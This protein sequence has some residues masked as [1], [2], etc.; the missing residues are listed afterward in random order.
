LQD[1][2]GSVYLPYALGRKYPKADKEFRWQ[3]LFPAT[4]ISVDPRSGIRRRHHLYQGVVQRYIKRTADMIGITKRVTCHTF[5]HSFAT[6]LLQSGADIR[7]VQQLLGHNDLKTT[8]IYT[9]VALSGPTGTRSPL[10]NAP[11]MSM[12]EPGFMP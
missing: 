4:Q 11:I 7:T 9:H 12:I 1:G 6:H 5:R 2:F 3:Y 10:D 8:M